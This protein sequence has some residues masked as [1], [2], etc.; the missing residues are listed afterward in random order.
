[1][2]IPLED[3]ELLF[4]GSKKITIIDMGKLFKITEIDSLEKQNEFYVDTSKD[5]RNEAY[6]VNT[7]MPKQDFTKEEARLKFS[8]L[9]QQSP[10]VDLDYAAYNR[11]GVRVFGY[12]REKT[13]YVLYWANPYEEKVKQLDG[14]VT[15]MRSEIDAY[16]AL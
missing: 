14:C 7:Y 9:K 8:H 3:Y 15:C 13:K 2:G 5:V 10:Y 11:W 6:V 1:M 4:V 16:Q 12:D